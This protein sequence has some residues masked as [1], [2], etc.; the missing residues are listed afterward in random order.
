MIIINQDGTAAAKFKS[1]SIR[2]NAES[3][4]G[5]SES[6]KEYFVI[7]NGEI[8]GR[9]SNRITAE[10]EVDGLIYELTKSRPARWYSL[11]SDRAYHTS[12]WLQARRERMERL[13]GP[14]NN[15]Y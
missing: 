10:A 15:E 14:T 2:P 8:Y 12:P 7:I 5:Q 1:V 13:H 3:T 4:E 6:E 9:Y 11:A